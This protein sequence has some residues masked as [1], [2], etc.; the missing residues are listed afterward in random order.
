MSKTSNPLSATRIES[1]IRSRFDPIRNLTPERLTRQLDDFNAGYLREAALTWDAIER[2]D[3]IVQT[4]AAKRKMSAGRNGWDV[5]TQDESARALEHREALEF[6]WRNVRCVNALDENETGSFSLLARQMMDAVGKRYAVHEIVW[7]RVDSRRLR[8]EFRFVPLWF[9]ENRTGRLRFLP[10]DY[11]LEGEPLER[12]RWVV[13][14][15]AGVMEP[16]SVAFL[17]KHL[18]LRDWLIYCE[19][20]GMPGVRGVTDAEPGSEEW[21]A[22]RDAV[23]AFGA[24]FR[25]L[26]TSGT[27]IEPVDLSTTGTLPY[28]ELVERMD[29]GISV[30][31]RGADLATISRESGIGASLQKDEPDLLAEGDAAML[32]D[33]LNEQVGRYVIRALFNEEPLA[34]IAVRPGRQTG[35]STDLQIYRTAHEMGFTIDER[36]FRERFGMAELKSGLSV[37]PGMVSSPPA[38]PEGSDGEIPVEEFMAS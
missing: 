30:L 19:R 16:C 23:E 8:A 35:I 33:T 24:E 1:H 29:R 7:D 13:T 12:G 37:I 11:A 31:W 10:S 5:L 4:A 17:Y 27:T 3:D 9:F 36:D 28:P 15:G 22:A 6:F 34:R 38:V 18:P 26:M 2:R 14:C 21:N 32:T 25:A 20:N